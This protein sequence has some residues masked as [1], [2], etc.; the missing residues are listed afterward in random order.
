ML[1]WFLKRRFVKIVTR[2][3]GAFRNFNKVSNVMQF[4]I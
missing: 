4:V 3:F 2:N 1:Q